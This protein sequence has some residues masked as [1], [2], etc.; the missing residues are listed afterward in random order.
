MN[1]CIT[2]ATLRK[3]LGV[4][5]SLIAI[6][7]IMQAYGD[8]GNLFGVSL[9]GNTVAKVETWAE[10]T[11]KDK[12]IG[13]GFWQTRTL[14]TISPKA[15][16]TTTVYENRER[17]LSAENNTNTSQTVGYSYTEE[18]GHVVSAEVKG[19]KTHF[20]AAVG[21][22]FSYATSKTY[23]ATATIPKKK[24]V[25]IWASDV[26][27]KQQYTTYKQQPQRAHNITNP[28]WINNGSASSST[29]LIKQ[30]SSKHL[31]FDFE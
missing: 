1:N 8:S 20:E 18:N 13:T 5:V 15:A 14:Y 6:A 31:T 22:T 24:K 23:S 19:K 11:W 16:N 12:W 2:K 28:S 30:Y 4:T 27:I 3:A 17:V 10:Q 7:F 21:Y 25:V 26:R 29:P 9:S